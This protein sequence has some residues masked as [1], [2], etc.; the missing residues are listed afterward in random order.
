MTTVESA[1]AAL[2]TDGA[3]PITC[4]SGRVAESLPDAT[5]RTPVF[6]VADR[7]F[8]LH[9]PNGLRVLVEDGCEVTI[10]RPVHLS[11]DDELLWV[12]GSAWGA[13]A[14]YR[15]RPKP[16]VAYDS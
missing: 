9:V 11:E 7:R 16:S 12:L 6:E 10:D 3:A 2:E 1:C 13:L 14:S 15:S 8:L 4:R 5:F